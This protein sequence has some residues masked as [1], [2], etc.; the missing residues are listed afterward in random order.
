MHNKHR[1]KQIGEREGEK[2]KGKC[3]GGREVW[4][5]GRRVG[6]VVKNE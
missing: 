1:G 5:E 2:R 3:E 4:S 6:D